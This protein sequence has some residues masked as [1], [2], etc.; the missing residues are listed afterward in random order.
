M[1]VLVSVGTNAGEG[2]PALSTLSGTL[3]GSECSNRGCAPRRE[4][5][6]NGVGPQAKASRVV[7][8]YDP[9]SNLPSASLPCMLSPLFEPSSAAYIYSILSIVYSRVQAQYESHGLFFETSALLITFVCLGEAARSVTLGGPAL[10]CRCCM[11][12]SVCMGRLILN[13]ICRCSARGLAVASRAGLPLPLPRQASTW[14]PLP[15]AAHHRPSVPCCA[16][17]PPPPSCATP[18]SRCARASAG[19]APALQAWPAA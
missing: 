10:P 1:D 5:A 7:G 12:R 6:F 4:V 18:T 14:R 15:R 16:W 19:A 11:M 13:L 9:P 2:E 3:M 17:P 8:P